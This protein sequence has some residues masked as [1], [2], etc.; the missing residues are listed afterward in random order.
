M[1]EALMNVTGYFFLNIVVIILELTFDIIE[2]TKL[3]DPRLLTESG[4]PLPALT[5]FLIHCCKLSTTFSSIPFTTDMPRVTTPR[6][7]STI[8]TRNTSYTTMHR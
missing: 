2:A 4:I 5:H 1:K 6:G 3:I 7:T 8:A